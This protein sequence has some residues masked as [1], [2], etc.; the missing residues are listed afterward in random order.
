V[1]N[2]CYVSATFHAH[3]VSPSGCR[4]FLFWLISPL[5]PVRATTLTKPTSH[6]SVNHPTGSLSDGVAR[7][8]VKQFG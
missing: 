1:T 7:L 6:G 8:C 5:G 3:V 4:Y 2:T